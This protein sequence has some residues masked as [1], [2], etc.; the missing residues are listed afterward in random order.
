MPIYQELPV[1][2]NK[3]Q[4]IDDIRRKLKALHQLRKSL[5]INNE[6]LDIQR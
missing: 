5:N 3:E 2:Q 4:K 1:E 6:N